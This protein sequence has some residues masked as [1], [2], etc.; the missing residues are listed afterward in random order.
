MQ[1]ERLFN[2][3]VVRSIAFNH[4]VVCSDEETWGAQTF[5]LLC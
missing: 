3:I 5:A 4:T 2:T 1:Q